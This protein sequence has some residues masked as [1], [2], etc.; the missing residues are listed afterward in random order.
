MYVPCAISHTECRPTRCDV[1]AIDM[2]PDDVLLIIFDIFVAHDVDEDFLH[3]TRIMVAEDTEVWQSLVHVCRRWRGIVF[4]SPRR[5]N[6]QLAYTRK[7]L[8]METLDVWPAFPIRIQLP[9]DPCQTED[10]DDIVAV[11]GRGDR[12]NEISLYVVDSSPLQRILGAM[13][14]PFPELTH[15]LLRSTGAVPVLPDSFLGGSAPRLRFLC[16]MRISFPGLP[17]LLLSVTHLVSL[18]LDK[19]TRSGY[20]SPDAMVTA[21]ST[22]T[23]LRSFR[24]TFQSLQSRPDHAS[25]SPLPTTRTVL[26]A[27]TVFWFKGVSEYLDDFVAR[28]DAPRLESLYLTFFNQTVFDT[29]QIVQFISRTPMLTAL[30]QARV[31]FGT[32]AARVN[33]SSRTSPNIE[34]DVKIPCIELDWQVLYLEQVFTSCLPPLPTLEDLYIFRAPLSHPHWRDNIEITLWPELL[35]SF[36]TVKNLYL[37]DEF[38]THIGP[39][40]QEFVG[41]NTTEVLPTL[42]KI[43]LESLQ[44]SDYGSGLVQ[45]YIGRLVATRQVNGRPIEV[46]RWDNPEQD[47]VLRNPDL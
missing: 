33:I 27:L 44:P 3:D 5:L 29:P 30:G 28:I 4:E 13:K 7:T 38:A 25:R 24:L 16:L 19:I 32:G 9:N 43:F 31:V 26:P 15:L 46:F 35:H 1:G 41:E 8:A 40:L 12:V 11:L 20:L 37:S 34:I 45:R 42:Q 2:L 36:S 47:K 10:A 14:E 17:K 18:R 6:L 23:S 22:L 21:L 39:A